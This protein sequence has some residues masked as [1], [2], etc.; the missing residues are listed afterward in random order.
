MAK[1]D[2][3]FLPKWGDG[4]KEYPGSKP[5]SLGLSFNLFQL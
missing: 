5:S 4:A 3:D 2:R 1:D